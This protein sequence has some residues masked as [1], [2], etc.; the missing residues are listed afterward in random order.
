M[1]H[2]SS[3]TK[4]A[5]DAFKADDRPGPIHMLN[6]IRLRDRAEYPD[7]T[8]VT[9]RAAYEEYGKLSAPIFKRV[10]GHI[11]WRGSFELTMIGPQSE[12]WDICFIAE[13]PSVNAFVEMTRD[14][15]YREAVKHRQA[16]VE[17]SRLVRLATMSSGDSF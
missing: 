5:W 17:N 16:G 15:D 12:N 3:Y 7:G 9:G 6:L 2:Y 4:D 1:D 11:V 10:G 8:D 13:Y 14:G